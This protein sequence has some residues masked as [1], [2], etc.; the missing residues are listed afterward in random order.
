MDAKTNFFKVAKR[1]IVGEIIIFFAI[2]LTLG[3]I[4]GTL[5]HFGLQGEDKRLLFQSYFALGIIYVIVSLTFRAK[6][7]IKRK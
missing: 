6:K 4:S 1:P 3:A 7:I 5:N 2:F